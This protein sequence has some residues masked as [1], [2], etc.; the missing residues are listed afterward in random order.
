MKKW[1]EEMASREKK[2]GEESM[3]TTQTGA[4]SGDI[5]EQR[6][7]KELEWMTEEDRKSVV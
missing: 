3:T 6:N 2:E 1:R 7:W 5:Q 4:A